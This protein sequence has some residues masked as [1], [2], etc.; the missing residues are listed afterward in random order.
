[1]AAV[2][3]TILTERQVEVLELREQGYTQQEVAEKIGTTDSNVSAVERAATKNVEKA[4]RTLRLVDTLSASVTFEV[5][6][7]TH[8]GDMIEMVYSHGDTCDIKI[9]YCRPELYSYLYEPLEKYSAGNKI[10]RNVEIGLT[11]DGDVRVF[12]GEVN[13]AISGF[14][15]TRQ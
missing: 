8:F 14:D 5:P 11:H 6:A 9:A 7:G 15:E 3:S 13:D 4:K 12:P 10:R 2:D 1:M